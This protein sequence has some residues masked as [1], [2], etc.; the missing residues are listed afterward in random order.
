MTK[1]YLEISLMGLSQD[2]FN[3]KIEGTVEQLRALASALTVA[4]HPRVYHITL[5][6]ETLLYTG[7]VG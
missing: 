2:F 1:T 3:M 4:D 6:E 7:G 5:F